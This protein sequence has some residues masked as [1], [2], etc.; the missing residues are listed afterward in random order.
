MKEIEVLKAEYPLVNKLI[1]TEEI[2]WI[3]PNIEKYE[4][5]I[6]ASPLN[7]EDVKDAEERLKRFAPYIAKVFPETKETNGIIESPLVKIPSMKQSLEKNYGQLILGKLLLKCDSHL[8]ISG[9]IKARGGIYEVLKHAEQLALQHGMLTEED[10]YSILDSDT[11]REFF[12]KYSIAVGSTGNLGLSIGIMSAKLGFNV[13]V[14]MSADAKEWKK[15]LL[16]NK[17]VNVIEYEADYS[18]A[19]EEGRQQADADPSCYFVDD[20]NSHDLF[21]GY[22]VAASRLQKQLEELE[23]IVDEEHPLF[24]YLPC[25]VGGGP[26]GVA[27]G[28]KLLYKN[29]VHCFFAEPTHSPCMLLGLMTGLHDKIAVQDIG[30]DNITDADGLAVGRPSGFVGKTIEPF[31]NGNYTVSDEELYRLLKE[32]ADKENINLEPSALAGMV[33]PV[34]VCKNENEYLQ[35][36]QL[37]ETVKK[38]THIVW[39]TGGSMVP[40]DVMNGY[41]KKGLELTI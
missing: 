3:N 27:F 35:K 39:G 24:V 30:I 22:A 4:T 20:E 16:R 9:S 41:Y 33:G 1:A 40:E 14:H 11:C 19:V 2:F 13:T 25:G 17:G 38:G 10:K 5:A 32:L 6:T 31:L 28:L 37:T 29:N 23:I 26:G 36:Q 21:L 8:P 15:D 34:N 12:A 18:K 7:E